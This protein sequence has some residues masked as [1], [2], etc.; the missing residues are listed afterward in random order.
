MKGYLEWDDFVA[1][2]DDRTNGYD[3][4]EQLNAFTPSTIFRDAKGNPVSFHQCC[5]KSFSIAANADVLIA[6]DVVYDRSVI[7]Q[8]VQ[9]VKSLL[10]SSSISSPRKKGKI[11]IFATTFR[12]AETFAIFEE[13]LAACSD[14]INCDYVDEKDL[15]S[16]PYIFPCYFQQPRR[17]V[18]ICIMSK[19]KHE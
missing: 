19:K 11:A 18:R 4:H 17:H 6:A 15:E 5:S 10:N 14:E 9:V 2:N 13:E 12:N 3:K 8:L 7:P 1:V 16:M